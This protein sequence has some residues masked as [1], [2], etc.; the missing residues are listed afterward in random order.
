VNPVRLE[1][2]AGYA[3]VAAVIAIAVLALA[4]LSLI[5]TG[6]GVGA[7]IVA[8]AERAR[9]AAAADAALAIAIRNLSD[10]DRTRRWSIDGRPRNLRF[11]GTD[12]VIT[13]EDERGK[14]P[15]NQLADE[16][17]RALFEVLGA[18]GPTLDSRTDAF[19]DW[20]DE[21][22]EARPSGAEIG[23]YAPLGLRPRNGALR[24]VEELILIRGMTP[25]IVARLRRT[26][27]AYGD[28][29]QGFDDR[30]ATPLALSVISGGGLGS[31]A[32]INR[33]RELAGQRVA[34][35]LAGGDVLTGRPLTIR[36]VARRPG[37]SR[38]ERGTVV[39]LTGNPAT[40]YVVRARE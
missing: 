29:Q 11:A 22:D 25:D 36:V 20:L 40:P 7:S 32:V 17:A 21:D 37:G 23:Y 24:S 13:V 4:S 26:A 18:S 30:Y 1:T 16:Q 6:R 38:L 3:M 14:V 27:T 28:R 39:E 10:P 33:E 35:E 9:L 2:E 5:E 31:P 8:E 34:I 19:L 12:V 15:L